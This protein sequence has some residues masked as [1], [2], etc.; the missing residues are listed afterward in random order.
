MV[1]RVEHDDLEFT[2]YYADG[3]HH[4]A[5][6]TAVA[7]AML[8]ALREI[9]RHCAEPGAG[10]RTPSDF[11]LA[12]LDQS[13]VDTLVGD[14]RDVE[15]IYPLTPMQSGMV[16]HAL[17]QSDERVYFQQVAFVLE[18]VDDPLSLER[19]W[20]RVVD[21][22]PVL[23]TRIVWEG[24]SEP[25]QVVQRSVIVP[26]THHDWR[27]L[28]E[29]ERNRAWQD[30]LAADR[31]EGLDLATTP[32]LRVVLARSVIGVL[33]DVFAAYAGHEP[34]QRRPFRDY[35][36]WLGGQ[37]DGKSEEYWRRVLGDLTDP[38]RLP[39][40]RAPAK[41]HRT[42]SSRWLRVEVENSTRLAPETGAAP[43]PNGPL[44][45]LALLNRPDPPCD[46]E[47]F[48][49][50]LPADIDPADWLEM[51]IADAKITAD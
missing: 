16:F 42:R 7:D 48:G 25:V 28:S 32:L 39:F 51:W 8:A 31:A 27:G 36:E 33:S 49:Q 12:A 43:E 23:R 50:H 40:D 9:I 3:V 29:V 17:S 37:D 47:I 6:I 38:A 22:T 26:V 21:R 13:T 1:G 45:S 35:L 14:G 46:L 41:V 44:I 19:A 11:P 34:Q 5:T 24:I 30:V 10:G 18:G 2:W 4:E 15:D 20:Q